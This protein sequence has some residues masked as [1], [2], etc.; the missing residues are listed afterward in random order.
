METGHVAGRVGTEVVM[1]IV[2]AVRVKFVA[3][4]PVPVLLALLML[5]ML[6]AVLTA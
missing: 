6:L 2:A 3:V 1:L 5:L 4:L